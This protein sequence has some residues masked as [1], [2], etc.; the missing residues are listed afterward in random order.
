[1]S[2]TPEYAEEELVLQE[3]ERLRR[4]GGSLLRWEDVAEDEID[5]HRREDEELSWL[6]AEDNEAHAPGA[7]CPVCGGVIGPAQDAR[8]RADGGW[9]HQVCPTAAAVPASGPE[10]AARAG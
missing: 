8:A 6:N 7:V 10:T 2:T 1:M 4:A 3:E 9:A 5:E